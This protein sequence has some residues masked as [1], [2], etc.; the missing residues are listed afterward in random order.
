MKYLIK[1]I[2]PLFR[3]GI[4][5]KCLQNSAESEERHVPAVCGIQREAEKNEMIIVNLQ[6]KKMLCHNNF[7][8]IIIHFLNSFRN[9]FSFRFFL[10][11]I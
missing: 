4:E 2:F 10:K 9:L 7:R 3:S 11:Y 6:H 1:F 8:I 5:A